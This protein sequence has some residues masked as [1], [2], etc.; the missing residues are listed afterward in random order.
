MLLLEAGLD[1]EDDD[2]R[3]PAFHG[4]AT[5]HPGMSWNFFVR[6]YDDQAQQDR[7]AKYRPEHDGVLYP[8]SATLGGCTAH[9]AMITV[10]PH[11]A[12]W[13]GIADLTGD[14]SW[15]AAEMRRWFERLEACAYKP[16]PADAAAA[17]LAGPAAGRA[18][19]GER[20]VRQPEPARLRRLAAHHAGRPEA[21]RRATPQLVEVLLRAFT[22]SLS[23]FWA[24][25]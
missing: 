4:R 12:D 3:V 13:D 9:N 11:D 15:R 16:R 10:Y 19:A 8:R 14:P 6:H 20:Q 21:R 1:D 17:P 23:D 24:G 2:Y 22:A 7:D 25:R 5:E 18:A